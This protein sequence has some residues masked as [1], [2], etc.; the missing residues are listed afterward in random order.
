MGSILRFIRKG[1]NRYAGQET[2]VTGA[3]VLTRQR[4]ERHQGQ[5]ARFSRIGA[6]MRWL[7]K[8]TQVN[9]EVQRNAADGILR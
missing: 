8:R 9:V 3:S 7:G 1:G 5:F 4:C 2:S 6:R